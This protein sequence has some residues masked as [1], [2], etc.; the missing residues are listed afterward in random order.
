MNQI[1][2]LNDGLYKYEVPLKEPSDEK[3]IIN[4]DK[5]KEDQFWRTPEIKR[6]KYMQE[7]DRIEY[8]ERERQRWSEGVYILINGEL[9]YL[10]GMHYDHMTYMTF[11]G[12]KPVY[13]DHQRFDFYFRDLTRREVKCRGRVIMKPRRYGMTMQEVTEATY[14]LDDDFSNNVALQS[15]TKE[16]VRTTLLTPLINSYVNRPKFMRSDY[17]KPNGKLLVTEINLN[18]NLAPGEDGEQKGDFLLGWAKGFPALPR[19]LDGNEVAYSVMSEIWKWQESS[20]KETLESNI[21]VLMGFQRAGKVSL[22]STMGD[23]DDYIGS[24]LDGFDIIARSNPE[25]RDENGYTLSGLYEYFVPATYS[26]DIPPEIFE[27]DKYGKVNVDKHNTYIHNTINKHDKN[28]KS[29]VFELRRLPL[30]K[31]DALMSAQLTTLFRKVAIGAALQK[32]QK[33]PPDKKPYV[34]GN[35]VE[36]S[37]GRVYFEPDPQG[38]WMWA[39]LPYFSLERKIDA[40]NRWTFRNGVYYPPTNQEGA[41]GYDPINYHKEQT[42]SSSLSRASIIVHKKF[43][44][45]NKPDDKDYVADVKMGLCVY[46]PDDPREANKEAIKAAKFTGFRVMHEKSVNHPYEDFMAAGMLPFLMQHKGVYGVAPS[47][48]MAQKD[49]LAL[50]QQRYKPPKEPGDIDQLETYP[51]EAG[52]I[53]LD[54]FDQANPTPFD[55]TSSEKLLELGLKQVQWTN[56]TDNSFGNMLEIIHE[57]IVPRKH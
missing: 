19:S 23:S 5:K 32:L 33:L 28:S 15:D 9:I 30:K 25:I 14:T 4:F 49:A 34:R 42:T 31:T 55:V 36:N 2:P 22:E 24:V 21:K 6:V 39:V 56:V 27:Y 35:L 29:Y 43:D 53:D 7:K 41:I 48:A 18:S 13:F 11:K 37:Y 3:E 47:D 46:R 8:I 10:T 57:I 40:R 12:A 51:F 50:L 26:F 38:I 1:I 45:F 52:L 44:Y 20:P 17:Y 16:K 54:S